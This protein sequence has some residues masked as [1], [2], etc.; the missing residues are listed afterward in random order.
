[1]R[2]LIDGDK[3]YE[4]AT[5]LTLDLL[6]SMDK[7]GLDIEASA[8]WVALFDTITAALYYAAPSVEAADY[9]IEAAKQA[10]LDS[11]NQSIH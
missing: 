5:D 8:A 3:A 6:D 10:A 7:A 11:Q 4:L 1:M 2:H 9:V